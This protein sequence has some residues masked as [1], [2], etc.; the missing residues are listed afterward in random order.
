[1]IGTEALASLRT[2]AGYGLPESVQVQRATR[3]QDGYGG[4]TE[5][6]ASVAT[7]AGRVAVTGQRPD[8]REIAAQVQ[9]A[10]TYTVTLPA[11]TDVR[12]RD[13]LAVGTRTFE[14]AGVVAGSWE[15]VRRCVC[16][17]IV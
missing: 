2:L 17:E 14:V 9:S 5:A 15:V 3:T 13:R 4:Q 12:A 6:W 11:G 8:E 7:V 1:M 10:V 16:V